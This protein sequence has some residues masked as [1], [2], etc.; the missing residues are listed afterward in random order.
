MYAMTH[1]LPFV[2]SVTAGLLWIGV[3]VPIVSRLFG[4]RLP[5]NL[6]KRNAA[7]RQLSF[8]QYIWL[9]GVVSVGVGVSISS[10]VDEY[11]E[12]G[13]SGHWGLHASAASIVFHLAWWSATGA[14]FGWYMWGFNSKHATAEP[15]SSPR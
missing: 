14:F 4:V 6:R 8:G 15:K 10:L 13:F 11:L 12:W 1:Y 9:V 5:I 3:F 2:V 7:I